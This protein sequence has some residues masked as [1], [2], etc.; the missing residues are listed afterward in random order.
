MIVF[1][2]ATIV[3][4]CSQQD[5][6]NENPHQQRSPQAKAPFGQQTPGAPGKPESRRE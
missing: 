4:V 1:K 2:L 5:K 6:N 3:K